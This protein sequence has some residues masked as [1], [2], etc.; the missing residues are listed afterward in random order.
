MYKTSSHNTNFK[1]T[2][3][4]AMEYQYNKSVNRQYQSDIL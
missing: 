1:D 3:H 4:I 2:A